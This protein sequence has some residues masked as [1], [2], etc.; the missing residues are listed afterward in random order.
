MPNCFSVLLGTKKLPHTR[1]SLLQNSKTA[2]ERLIKI[3]DSGDKH[4]VNG[5]A[6]QKICL[7]PPRDL[8]IDV[9]PNLHE[10]TSMMRYRRLSSKSMR[11]RKQ[12]LLPSLSPP[13]W[14]TNKTNIW[15]APASALDGE[16]GGF[17]LMPLRAL[18]AHSGRSNRCRRARGRF[19]ADGKVGFGGVKTGDGF[20]HFPVHP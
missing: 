11:Y 6:L 20:H 9:M 4:C 10:T 14:T 13:V 7:Y 17:P 19:P 12:S 3:N 15:Q 18:P 16:R 2:T 8:Q 1:L 5:V